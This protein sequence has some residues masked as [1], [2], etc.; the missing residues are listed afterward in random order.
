MIKKLYFI[1]GFLGMIATLAATK[2][3][4]K[5]QWSVAILP[6]KRMKLIVLAGFGIWLVLVQLRGTWIG[7]FFQ[8]VEKIHFS[9]E[10]GTSN[11]SKT[12][13]KTEIGPKT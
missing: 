3:S 12:E 11:Q 7:S 2:N 1:S 9:T 13:T 6:L 8:N 4:L 5:K 10:I